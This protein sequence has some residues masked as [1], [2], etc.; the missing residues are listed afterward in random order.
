MEQQTHGDAGPAGAVGPSGPVGAVG[1]A[2]PAGPVGPA[3]A[4]VPKATFALRSTAGQPGQPVSA[5]CQSGEQLVA[6]TCATGATIDDDGKA[7]CPAPAD[8]AASA[9]LTIT[10]AP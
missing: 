7:S 5:Q 4:A 2:G 3:G 8:A 10:C 1:P 9:R 6:A